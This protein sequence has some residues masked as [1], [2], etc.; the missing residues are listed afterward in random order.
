MDELSSASALHDAAPRKQQ[1][2][3]SDGE[4][5]APSAALLAEFRS[6][7]S[8]TKA[9]ALTELKVSLVE[10]SPNAK[11]LPECA[12]VLA[13]KRGRY[14]EAKC[15]A[16]KLTLRNSRPHPE[17]LGAPVQVSC[18]STSARTLGSPSRTPLTALLT[19]AHR[20]RSTA[21]AMVTSAP[22]SALKL[23]MKGSQS[24]SALPSRNAEQQS[25]DVATAWTKSPGRDDNS[26]HLLP[27]LSAPM[28]LHLPSGKLTP[29]SQWTPPSS[30]SSGQVQSVA[31]V[32]KRS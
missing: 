1:Q 10:R 30:K 6:S 12:C 28:L 29:A 26:E 2:Q 8:I 19:Q 23:K 17:P 16:H 4:E 15:E 31:L 11:S 3:Q 27:S 5:D 25:A 7:S 20:E 13:L 18:C 21:A 32:R 22:P 9:Q 24:M 14:S